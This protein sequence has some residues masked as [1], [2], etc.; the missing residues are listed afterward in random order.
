[1]KKAN[2]NSKYF[3]YINP[4]FKIYETPKIQDQMQFLNPQRERER[5]REREEE[6]AQIH[7]RECE[8]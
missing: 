5:E 6:E 8:T 4:H 2:F 1:M 7:E 3:Q